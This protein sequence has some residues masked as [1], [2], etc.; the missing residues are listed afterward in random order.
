MSREIY[1]PGRSKRIHTKVYH[2][3]KTSETSVSRH[4][5]NC[6]KC[7][8][9]RDDRRAHFGWSRY[10]QSRHWARVSMYDKD[11]IRRW[12]SSVVRYTRV[13]RCSSWIGMTYRRRWRHCHTRRFCQGLRR[14]GRF[15]YVRWDIC[16]TRR[17]GWRHHHRVR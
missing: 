14:W 3:C 9:Q 12:L 16:R 8:H 5:T 11:I 6:L 17:D 1:L 2:N 13:R 7:R 15:H 4:H 10:Y